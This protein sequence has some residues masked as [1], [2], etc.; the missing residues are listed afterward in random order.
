VG[1]G[2]LPG[3]VS[4]VA[5]GDDVHVDAIGTASFDDDTPLPVPGTWFRAHGF[6]ASQAENVLVSANTGW[7]ASE[8]FRNHPHNPDS[9]E[10]LKGCPAGE[11]PAGDDPIHIRG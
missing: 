10:R 5:R 2:R 9:P 7:L 1:P 11:L 6:G 4:L 8:H 3:L